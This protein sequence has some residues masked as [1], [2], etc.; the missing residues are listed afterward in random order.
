MTPHPP[1]TIVYAWGETKVPTRRPSAPYT[2]VA[3]T[4]IRIVEPPP[5]EAP[6]DIRAAWVGLELPTLG[7]RDGP[8]SHIVAG[9]LSGE[10]ATFAVGYAV[11]GRAAVELLA[12]HAPDA[13]AWWRTN[14]PHV[15]RNGFQ[16]VFPADVCRKVDAFR[17]IPG[18]WA[19]TSPSCLPG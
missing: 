7:D 19:P 14:A 1:E 2:P 3:T 5:G 9:V 8:S 17:A 12:G 4:R 16:L 10:E 15:L 13:A 18:S 11:S 6:A